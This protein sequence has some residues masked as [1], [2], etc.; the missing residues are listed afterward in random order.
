[1]RNI[2]ILILSIFCFSAH[3]QTPEVVLIPKPQQM[4]IHNGSFNIDKNTSFFFEPEFEIAGNFFQDFLQNSVG[5]QL[6]KKSKDKA[7]ILIEKDGS[8]PAEGY[9]LDISDSNIK[10]KAS[11]A[12][13]A[14]Y[15]IQTLRQLLPPELELP[16]TP[17]STSSAQ[18]KGEIKDK[19]ISLP[20][21][22]ITDFP[23][24]LKK[25]KLKPK[26]IDLKLPLL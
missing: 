6:T 26:K 16:L 1:M 25:S 5:F 11:D 13:G 7:Q 23:K 20:Q 12:S 2:P 18:R 17:T 8:Q 10:I 4:K 9:S 19:A 14:F 3:S 21:L 22:T 24:F 15:A